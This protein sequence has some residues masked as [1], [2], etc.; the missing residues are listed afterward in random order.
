MSDLTH[1]LHKRFVM[2]LQQ[3]HWPLVLCVVGL[4]CIGLV[5]LYSAAG[6]ELYPWALKQ[7]MH[8]GMGL[9]LILLCMLLPLRSLLLYAYHFY[10]TALLLLFAVDVMGHTG[11]GA[12]RWLHFGFFTLQPVELMKLAV[13]LALARYY[14][15]MNFAYIGSIPL[16]I[17]PLLMIALPCVL[18]LRQPSLGGAILL[19]LIGVTL[20]FAA[21]NSYVEIF[22]G[23]G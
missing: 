15:R 21:G 12:Q 7:M 4:C 6:G 20:I 9:G 8:F 13:I 17:P 16:L 22:I 2:G 3:F 23:G 1:V 18:V 11:M 19:C 5:M 10:G 14:H